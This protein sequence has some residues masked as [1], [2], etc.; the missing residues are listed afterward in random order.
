MMV[1]RILRR[2]PGRRTT[3][4]PGPALLTTLLVLG[5]LVVACGRGGP[6]PAA[7]PES[8]M[9]PLATGAELYYDDRGGIPEETREVVRDPQDWR[10]YWERATS[11]RSDP[12]PLPSLDFDEYMVLVVGAGRM[13]P[14]DRIE[15]DS[16]G[17]R[18]ER[19]TEDEEEVFVV[20][21]RTIE[22]CGTIQ[23]DAYPLQIVRVPRYDGR[24]AFEVR[25]E[26]E[27]CQQDA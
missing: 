13:S 1:D 26:Q 15:V 25:D 27:E 23:G 20:V 24:V 5:P 16:A 4:L 21:V 19:T 17:V 3:P 2:P 22:G 10:A 9:V 18:T 6:V 11:P 14:G 8:P 7:P 12:P